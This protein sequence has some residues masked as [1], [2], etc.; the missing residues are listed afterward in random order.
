MNMLISITVLYVALLVYCKSAH[1]AKQMMCIQQVTLCK[2]RS[3]FQNFLSFA[4]SWQVPSLSFAT[5]H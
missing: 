5:F 1:E 4:H 2:I 3:S